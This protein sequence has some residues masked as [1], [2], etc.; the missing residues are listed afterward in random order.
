[1]PCKT[2]F[3]SSWYKFGSNIFEKSE[4]LYEGIFGLIGSVFIYL[5]AFAFLKGEALYEKLDA[6][7]RLNMMTAASDSSPASELSLAEE[8]L[9]EDHL[10]SEEKSQVHVMKVET[11]KTPTL[12][13]FWIPFV[14]VLREG[15]ETVMFIGGVAFGEP[16]SSIPLAAVIGL[17]IGAFVGY[18]IHRASGKLSL[19]WFFVIASYILFLMA[20]GIFSRSVGKLEDNAF[21]IA[22]S[23]HGDDSSR[24]YFD[25]RTN[26]W[27]LS[28]CNE[29]TSVGFGFLYSLVGYRSVATVGTIV[30]YCG[31]W[32]A[33]I[34]ALLVLKNTSQI[35][36]S[37][38]F[39]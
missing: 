13:F 11:E 23:L 15:L 20:A 12:V 7:L 24:P 1:M 22:A 3:N 2:L 28:C 35:K 34:I 14:T 16:S 27:Y 17:G 39:A 21:N 8:D 29:T 31:Y 33:T 6:K 36:R 32:I 4:K 19:R 25:P 38:S 26:I 9:K 10:K 30:S 18:L 37:L 5:T